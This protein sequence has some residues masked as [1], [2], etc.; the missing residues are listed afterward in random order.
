MGALAAADCAWSARGKPGYTGKWA[1]LARCGRWTP[2]SWVQWPVRVEWRLSQWACAS[3]GSF[4]NGR[5]T[6]TVGFLT[7]Q[8]NPHSCEARLWLVIEVSAVRWQWQLTHSVSPTAFVV[9]RLA[10]HAVA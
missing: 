4:L 5:C 8:F 1:G 7:L 2:R 10:W 3:T 9:Q 6:S